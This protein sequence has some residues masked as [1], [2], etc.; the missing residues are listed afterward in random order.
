MWGINTVFVLQFRLTDRL[1]KCRTCPK[2]LLWNLQ[3]SFL[4][5]IWKQWT[6]VPWQPPG[7][8]DKTGK[9]KK[10]WQFTGKTDKCFPA[11]TIFLP[12]SWWAQKKI[13]QICYDLRV[14]IKNKAAKP[15]SVWRKPMFLSR[16]LGEKHK[17]TLTM[18]ASLF[19]FTSILP[20]RR[21]K[22]NQSPSVA[23]MPCWYSAL[24]VLQ[25]GGEVCYNGV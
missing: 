18:I 24:V 9:K 1:E 25:T 17:Q 4:F 21:L 5:R 10:Y 8:S 16:K 6:D 13:H 20:W 14:C 2:N 15:W 12:L 11:D 23:K 3:M 7:N 22:I 19:T